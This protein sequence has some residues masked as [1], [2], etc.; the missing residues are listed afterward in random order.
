MAKKINSGSIIYKISLDNLEVLLE[1]IRDLIKL[2]N[3][4]L[5]KIDNDNLFIYSMVG[6]KLNVHAFKG[7]ILSMKDIFF[8]KSTVDSVLKFSISDAKRFLTSMLVFVKYMRSQSILDEVD[9]RLTYNEDSFCESLQIKNKK[10]KEEIACGDI[11]AFNSNIDIEQVNELMDVDKAM[12][13]FKIKKEDFDYI[14]AKTNIEKD[15]D[16]I[17]LNNKK[18]DISFGE[19]K[20]EHNVMQIVSDID[21]TVCFPKKYFKCINYEKSD[22]QTLYVFENETRGY[23]MVVSENTNLLISTE[24]SV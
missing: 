5:F 12:Y 2:D 15:N 1:K 22:E 20:W 18:G 10:S 6:E 17:Y 21:S 14:K 23:I 3:R 19:S 9:F 7:Y 24:M 4:V 13:S 8:V 16:V 11:S